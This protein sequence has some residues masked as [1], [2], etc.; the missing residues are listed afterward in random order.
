M[1]VNSTNIKILSNS[2]SINLKINL[3]VDCT[4]G[5]LSTKITVNIFLYSEVKHYTWIEFIKCTVYC[6]KIF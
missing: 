3:H 1:I 5:T 6:L 4:T 2:L